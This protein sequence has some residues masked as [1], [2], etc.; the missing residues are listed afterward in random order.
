MHLQSILETRANLRRL[1]PLAL[2]LAIVFTAA[3]P[4]L[5]ADP[6]AGASRLSPPS[7]PD[8]AHVCNGCHISTMKYLARY[9]AQFP[10]EQGRP[11]VIEMVNGD[12]TRTMHTMALISWRGGAWCRDEYFG[13]FSL[14]CAFEAGAD[15]EHLTARAESC[16]KSHSMEVI[17]S[18]GMPRRP[19]S[20]EE[21]S[22]DERL[23]QVSLASRILPYP[24]TVYWLR[25]GREEFPV[26]FFRPSARQIGV[27]DPMH[28]TS[29]A[30]CSIRDDAKVVSLVAARLGYSAGHVRV[31]LV[32]PTS[33]LLADAGGS[34]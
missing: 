32:I 27:Y 34:K 2:A 24:T 5:N 31:Q 8:D 16:Y 30:E 9:L 10:A 6:V 15:A 33:S 18:T 7:Y 17:R 12:R 28:G 4:A 29:V 25:S 11:L 21:M 19:G 14:G 3:A 13:V 22:Q 23:Q 26:A 20:P 1:A